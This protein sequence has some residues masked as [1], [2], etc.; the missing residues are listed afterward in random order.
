MRLGMHS[1]IGDN[2]FSLCLP[3]NCKIKSP[4]RGNLSYTRDFITSEKD[5]VPRS[6][7]PKHSP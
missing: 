2:L 7:K 6:S 3:K 1:K 5:L 4:Q